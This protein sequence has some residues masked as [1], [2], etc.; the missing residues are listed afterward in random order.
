MDQL[1]KFQEVYADAMGDDRSFEETCQVRSLKWLGERALLVDVAEMYATIKSGY[2]EFKPR[3]IRELCAAFP[4]GVEATPAREYSVA[5]YLHPR[6]DLVERLEIFVRD[7]FEADKVDWEK[8][9][10]RVWWD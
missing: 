8:T 5:I 10:L 2:N 7:H 1:E 4:E 9:N 6:L 3:M